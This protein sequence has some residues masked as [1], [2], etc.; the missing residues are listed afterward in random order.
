M[1]WSSDSCLGKQKLQK[2]IPF[3]EEVNFKSPTLA[4]CC[5]SSSFIYQKLKHFQIGVSL[6]DSAI[7][8]YFRDSNMVHPFF[9]L[10]SK[11]MLLGENKKKSLK[12][13]KTMEKV[14]FSKDVLIKFQ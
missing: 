8:H 10:N 5:L 9:A 12:G 13:K 2:K 7:Y 11:L 6:M 3:L 4:V 14:L 1:V